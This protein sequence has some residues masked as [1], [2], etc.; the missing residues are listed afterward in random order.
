MEGGSMAPDVTLLDLLTT[1]AKYTPSEAETI[2]MVVYMV[3]HGDVRL[4][5][6]FKGVRFDLDSLAAA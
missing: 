5:G 4:C 1:V 6:N 2:A 3:N